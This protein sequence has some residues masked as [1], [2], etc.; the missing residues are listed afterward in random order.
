MAATTFDFDETVNKR[1]SILKENFGASS[2]AQILRMA[3]ALLDLAREARETNR[4]LAVVKKGCEAEGV[5]P[6]LFPGWTDE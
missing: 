5:S 1:I 4:F 6:I 3:I 2:K